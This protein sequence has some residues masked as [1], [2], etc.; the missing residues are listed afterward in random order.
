MSS[1]T[2]TATPRSAQSLVRAGQ[3]REAGGGRYGRCRLPG[4][5]SVLFVCTG[6]IC[7]SPIAEG[8]VRALVAGDHK[9]VRVSSAGIVGWEG[10]PAVDEAVQ[11]AAELGADISGH[12]GRRLERRHVEAADLVVCMAAEHREAV[13]RLVPEAQA[14]VFGL[15][16]LVRLLEGLPADPGNE[17]VVDPIGMSQEVFRSVAADI[18]EWS[19]RLVAALFRSDTDSAPRTATV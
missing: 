17:D 2:L 4:V 8:L 1:P 18:E 9:E 15:K 6:N 13:R 11:A 3:W 19:D 7:R 12:R 10:S 16:E 14:K 5:A